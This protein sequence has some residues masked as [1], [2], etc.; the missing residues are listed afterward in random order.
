MQVGGQLE[1]V[2]G[3]GTAAPGRCAGRPASARRARRSASAGRAAG[4]PAGRRRRWRP[5]AGWSAGYLDGQV[6]GRAWTRQPSRQP[7]SSWAGVKVRTSCRVTGT[8]PA[9][10]DLDPCTC[11]RCRGRRRS[12]RWRCRSTTP[13]RRR[14]HP[15]GRVRRV[16]GGTSAP[17]SAV[18]WTVKD[19]VDASG[20]VVGRG[21]GTGPLDQALTGDVGEGE[22]GTVGTA[23]VT[24]RPPPP[25][26]PGGR[27]STPCPS[28]R[29]R[30]RRRPP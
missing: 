26:W 4:S 23:G 21:L 29:D 14:S 17:S 2:D 20:A 16:G 22:V 5:W 8:S 3:V 10:V 30:G 19:E 15:A 24:C 28:R 9:A 7:S 27:R 6:A 1:V 12:S 13:R 18:P 11:G 25:A